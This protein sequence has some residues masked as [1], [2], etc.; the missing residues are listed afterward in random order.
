MRVAWGLVALTVLGLAQLAT[1]QKNTP[2][3]LLQILHCAT[4]DKFGLPEPGLKKTD[5]LRVGWHHSLDPDHEIGEEFFIVLY[6]SAREGD[7]LVY[8]RDYERGRVRF[9]LVN[10]AR[11]TGGPDDLH[12][13]D[14]LGGI[15]TYNH[16]KRN[17]T[18]AMRN[19]KYSIKAKS[20][21][22]SFVNVGCHAP[23][24][25]D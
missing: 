18:I 1:A 17:V 15:W 20:L 21:L 25:P 13:I 12:L 22:G 9:Y 24:D 19:R 4:I 3:P 6:K 14:P 7:V 8:V 11:F 5:I 2:K 23:W 16:I 10:N